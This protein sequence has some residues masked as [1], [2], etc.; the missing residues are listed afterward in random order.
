MILSQLLRM[1][2][3]HTRAQEITQMNT[4]RQIIWTGIERNLN[5]TKVI[6]VTHPD[7][8]SPEEAKSLVESSS[9]ITVAGYQILKVVTQKYLN[10]S[11]YG[12]GS[13]K[14]EEIKA[15]VKETRADQIVV[16]E[17]L[18]SKQIHNLERLTGVQVIDRERLILNIFHSRATTKEAKLQIELAEI[19]YEMPRVR[20]NAKLTSGSTERPGKGG[21]GEYTV[22]VKFR[23]LKR[24][25]SIIKKKLDEVHQK[26]E[27]YHQNR[28]RT[29]MP[30]VSLVGY[31]SSGKTTLFNLLTSE[32]KETSN[33]LFTTLSTTTRSFRTNNNN[34]NNHN[35]NLSGE[36]LLIDTVGF[37]S[38]LPHYMI[39][40]FKSTLEESLGADLILLLID[41]SE[42][43]EDV[44]IK[45]QCCWDVLDDLKVDRSR[46]LVVLTKFDGA[47]ISTE[48]VKNI[49]NDL[50][51][52]NP[53]AIS[54]KTGYGIHKLKTMINTFVSSQNLAK[55]DLKIK[56][57]QVNAE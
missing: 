53:I 1:Q 10:N 46:V 19:R 47:T 48:P 8:F 2:I 32:Y 3:L 5:F 43:I 7:T 34:N 11:R 35:H 14:A 50:M 15:F 57:V 42:K 22:D 51:I 12:L 45:Y 21:M 52:P 16:D 36:S 26:R 30:I 17:H 44:K 41:V 33:S 6:L 37:I 23:D 4:I 28:S 18:T 49:A 20:E 29:K 54:S 31:T 38:R 9:S 24:R 13:G 56:A 55:E 25:I 40:A 39:E 27:L